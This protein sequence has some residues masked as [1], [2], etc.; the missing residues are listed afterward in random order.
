MYSELLAEG[1][2]KSLTMGIVSVVHFAFLLETKQTTTA[3]KSSRSTNPGTT[4]TDTTSAKGNSKLVLLLWAWAVIIARTKST[5]C[6]KG[7]QLLAYTIG[8]ED[9]QD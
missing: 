6:R 9:L 7:Y 4:M 5:Y 2:S 3:V 8:N 1:L